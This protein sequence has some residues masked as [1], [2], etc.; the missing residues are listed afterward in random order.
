M[1]PLQNPY[2]Y[3]TH[4]TA[5]TVSVC[6]LMLYKSDTS[7]TG[8]ATSDHKSNVLQGTAIKVVKA[9]AVKLT[10]HVVALL[11]VRMNNDVSIAK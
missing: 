4:P 8:P 6:Y 2:M 5:N 11:L 10:D 1:G 3:D 9:L 7:Y